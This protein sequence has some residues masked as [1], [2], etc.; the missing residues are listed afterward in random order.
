[1]GP[2]LG[3]RVPIQYA[4]S[5]RGPLGIV[6]HLLVDAESGEV[7]MANGQTTEDLMER[8]EALYART[9]P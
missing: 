2:V 3:W 4:P 9:T 5:R 8:A 7:T 1:M 6:G